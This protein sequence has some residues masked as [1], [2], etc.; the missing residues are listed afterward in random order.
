M[1][2]THY[3]IILSQTNP[4][5]NRGGHFYKTLP[6]LWCNKPEWQTF[7]HWGAN[8]IKLF[9]DVMLECSYKAGVSVPVKP[10]HFCLM[11]VSKA[12]AYPH[13]V[14]W[15]CFVLGLPWNI[16]LGL[17]MLARDKHSSL[18]GAFDSYC[19]KTFYNIGPGLIFANMLWDTSLMGWPWWHIYAFTFFAVV[20]HA[21]LFQPSFNCLWKMF[22]YIAHRLRL[23]GLH[24]LRRCLSLFLI[25]TLLFLSFFLLPYIDLFD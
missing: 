14:S 21:S 4:Q 16:R 6:V 22:Y 1:E 5:M 18:L 15:M 17:K 9:T 25:K 24:H 2:A 11:F 19:R 23:Y 13:G 10:F 3:F 12:A 8:V 20:K 7:P